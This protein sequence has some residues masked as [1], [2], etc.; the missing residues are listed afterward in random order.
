MNPQ[1]L[2]TVEAVDPVFYFIFGISA[3]MLIGITIVMIYFVIR[4]NRKRCPVPESQKDDNFWLETTWTIIPTIIVLMMFWYG[5]EGYLSLRRVPDGAMPIQANARMW[6]WL[7][8]YENGKTSDKLYVP[9]GQPIKVKLIADDVLHSF[10][11]PAFRVKRD[12]VP[13]ME[14]YVWFVADEAGSY[15][16]FCA[17]YCGVAHSSMV[18]TVEALPEAEFAAWLQGTDEAAGVHPGQALLETYGCLGC[19]SLDGSRKVGPTFKDIAERKTVIT[20]NGADKNI[21]ADR[22]YLIRSINEPNAEIVK[23]FPPA[24]PPY[25]GS[26]GDDELNQMVDFLMSD[27]EEMEPEKGGPAPEKK[28][29]KSSVIESE[30]HV[31]EKKEKHE[32]DDRPAAT[33][34]PAAKPDGA[35]LLQERGCLGCHSTDGSRLVGPSFLGIFN[36]QVT[37]QKAGEEKTLSSDRDYLR[38]AIVE[39]S[40]EIVVGYPPVMPPSAGLSEAEIDAMIETLREM[41]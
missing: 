20:V 6:S 28:V 14:T 41:K 31:E 2:T 33:H 7:F 15:D 34:Q 8:T 25:A 29:E 30:E 32:S 23:G 9:V 19:H 10:F 22:D 16:L 3:V 18:T 21:V 12:C 13:G 40:V 39:P 4:Y 27:E 1:T 36:R 24:M 38:R 37:V 17:E 11:V 35:K 5:W 26:I